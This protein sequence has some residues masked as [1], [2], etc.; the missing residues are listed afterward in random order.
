[1]LGFANRAGTTN[2]KNRFLVIRTRRTP[3]NDSVSSLALFQDQARGLTKP[4]LQ[5]KSP[6]ARS[7]IRC[8][9]LGYNGP[10]KRPSGCV[11]FAIVWHR[12]DDCNLRRHSHQI[13]ASAKRSRTEGFLTRRQDCGVC[14]PLC[15]SVKAPIPGNFGAESGGLGMTPFAFFTHHLASPALHPK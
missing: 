9:A 6:R 13:G 14:A 15:L 1:M 3:R 11:N 5:A 4:Q 10:A 8:G 2:T 12:S 7:E